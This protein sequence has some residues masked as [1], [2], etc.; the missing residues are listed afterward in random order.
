LKKFFFIKI[1]QAILFR[2]TP[3]KAF[4][5]KLM[6]EDDVTMASSNFHTE[7]CNKVQLIEKLIEKLPDDEGKHKPRAVCSMSAMK[8]AQKEFSVWWR[9]GFETHFSVQ[10]VLNF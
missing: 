2:S 10:C 5:W 1:S 4:K 8:G 9:I 3:Q 6:L 7:R